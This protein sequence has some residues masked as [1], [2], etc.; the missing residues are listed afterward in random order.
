MNSLKYLKLYVL[1]LLFQSSASIAG[2]ITVEFQGSLN[3]VE[4][5]LDTEFRIGDTVRGWYSY[6][7]VNP[8]DILADNDEIARYHV[9]TGYVL[10]V[11]GQ[12]W[13]SSH[14]GY[15]QVR[16]RPT[17]SPSFPSEERYSVVQQVFS[18]TGINRNDLYLTS[19]GTKAIS[20]INELSG[21]EL[22]SFVPFDASDYSFR[23]LFGRP[24]NDFLQME[25]DIASIS[26]IS[27]PS[28]AYLFLLGV[29]G[30]VMRN[31]LKVNQADTIN[32]T[33]LIGSL[34]GKGA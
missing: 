12:S 16:D 30:I 6:E 33:A 18:S 34:E 4:S 15:I 11:S 28:V 22:P 19:L 29:F 1:L 17:T 2:L 31:G 32:R 13:V 25:A 20:G 3:F 27:E 14:N 21:I 24:G 5:G 8:V 26:V 7:T 9:L 23:F 10:S